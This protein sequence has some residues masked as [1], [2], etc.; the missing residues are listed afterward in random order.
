M[1]QQTRIILIRH[2]ASHHADDGVVGGPRGCRG[3]TNVG[4]QQAE[5]LARRLNRE[6]QEPPSAVYCS[7]L[8]RAVETAEILAKRPWACQPSS[9]TASLC[10]WHTPP[11]AD[12]MPW[13]EYRPTSSL[14]AEVSTARSS[15]AMNRG[16]K[17]SDVPGEPQSR[18]LPAMQGQTVLSV[19]RTWK[20][21]SSSLIVF[22]CLPLML[23][24]D[25]M[26]APASITEWVTGAILKPGPAL[27]AGPT[28]RQRPPLGP[29]S[30]STRARKPCCYG[31][32]NASTMKRKLLAQ[33]KLIALSQRAAMAG[34][35]TSTIFVRWRPASR[36]VSR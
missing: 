3:L 21:S 27:D 32:A 26:V 19:A 1:A 25:V 14:A 34:W 29:M 4:R 22:G 8:P 33:R 35:S 16:A 6:L 18:S 5:A 12:G 23:A 36:N 31:F 15:G 20:R 11:A 24:F 30:A 17:P 7:V 28:Q 2:G 10:T 9:R 13:S